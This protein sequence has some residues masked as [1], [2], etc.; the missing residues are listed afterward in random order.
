[1]PRSPVLH[2]LA[3]T[4]RH[5]RPLLWT[6]AFN[7]AITWALSL[8]LRAQFSSIMATS[9]GAQRLIGAFDLGV[10]ADASRRL[11][12]GPP[13]S[14]TPSALAIPLYL[15]VFFLLVPG[16][17]LTYQADTP[18]HLGT[19]FQTGI[20]SFWS[21]VRITL[22]TVLT[23][24]VVLGLLGAIQSA[25]ARHVDQTATGQSAFVL[26]QLGNL[27]ILLAACFL[28]LYFDLVEVHSVAL[29]QTSRPTGRPD[30]R[31]R[32]TLRPAWRTLRRHFGSS[33]LT[34][35]FLTAA[36]L[37]VAYLFFV[38]ALHHLAQ[39]RNWPNLL[40]AQAAVFFLL[41]TRFWQRAAES[42]LF[43][44]LNPTLPRSAIFAPLPANPPPSR[45]LELSMSTFPS[46]TAPMD[47]IFPGP[48]VDPGFN[49]DPVPFPD[50]MPSPEPI[51]PSLAAPDPGVFHHT[52]AENAN[53][54]HLLE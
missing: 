13:G 45:P 26:T 37:F 53:T 27:I 33:F 30:R 22:L 17:L 24:A 4:L 23:A 38:S 41:F 44:N 54:D 35:L 28:R 6:Y 51:S 50:P 8:G 10:V 18:L 52:P 39:P 31:V 5:P 43:Q 14:L 9:L 16:T 7:A 2:G 49:P 34:F 36:G 47:P 20:Q 3:L 40:L 46:P 1:M 32:A 15:L 25:W 12:D 21:F 48:P 29:A 11:A 42:V 19:L